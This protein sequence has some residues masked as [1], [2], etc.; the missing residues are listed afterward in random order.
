MCKIFEQN[1]WNFRPLKTWY[2]LGS[3]I[4]ILRNRMGS[5]WKVTSN[6][7][8]SLEVIQT[9]GRVYQNL[10][11]VIHWW[12]KYSKKVTFGTFFDIKLFHVDEFLTKTWKRGPVAS[13]RSRSGTCAPFP[14]LLSVPMAPQHAEISHKHSVPP[15]GRSSNTVKIGYKETVGNSKND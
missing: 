3:Y 6:Q 5:T 13:V 12:H 14:F 15:I 9:R 7:W 4:W 8:L 11:I 10:I 1:G 2:K